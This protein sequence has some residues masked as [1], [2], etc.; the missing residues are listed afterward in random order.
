VRSLDE[1][2]A[3]DVGQAAKDGNEIAVKVF[4]E[5]GDYIGIAVAGVVNVLNPDIVVIGGGVSNVGE[6][7]FQAVRASVT[8]R[9]MGPSSECVKIEPAELGEDA[10]VIGAAMTAT[11]IREG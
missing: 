10:G 9:A 8:R 2:S 1:L 4:G 6:P 3:R 5:V 11:G 7:L